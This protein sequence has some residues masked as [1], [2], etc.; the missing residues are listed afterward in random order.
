LPRLEAHF[1]HKAANS[2]LVDT[3]PDFG[4]CRTVVPQTATGGVTIGTANTTRFYRVIEGGTISKIRINVVVQS[5]NIAVAVYSNSGSGLAATP[6]TRLATS[7]SVACPAA[8]INDVS[9][10]STVTVAI[11]DWLAIGA[12]NT[13]ATFYGSNGGGDGNLSAG[14]IGTHAAFPP[15]TSPS[16][17][18]QNNRLISLIGVP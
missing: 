14:Q 15:A 10:G 2:G 6:G 18:Y 11:G 4:I 12:D 9:L 5:G 16:L 17:T 8:G 7:G 3:R 13:T 1:A